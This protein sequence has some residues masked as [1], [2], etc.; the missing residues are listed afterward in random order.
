MLLE[1][2]YYDPECEGTLVWDPERD[3]AICDRCGHQIHGVRI[4]KMWTT[5]LGSP[6]APERWIPPTAD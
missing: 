1:H 6:E 5:S 2:V 3:R 4:K